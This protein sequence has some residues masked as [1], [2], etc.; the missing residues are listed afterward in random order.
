DL[1]LGTYRLRFEKPG[2]EPME[3]N[4]TLSVNEFNPVVVKLKPIP[5]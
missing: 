3:L 4:L 5:Q 2:Y 1:P